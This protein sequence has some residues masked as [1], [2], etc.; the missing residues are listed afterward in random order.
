MTTARNSFCIKSHVFIDMH[1]YKNMSIY[2]SIYLKK[3]V[4]KI[5]LNL[6]YVFD[7][8]I[9]FNL[10]CKSIFGSYPLIHCNPQL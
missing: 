9:V 2:M 7:F 6:L 4:H 10:F 3:N 1:I 5:I 8:F